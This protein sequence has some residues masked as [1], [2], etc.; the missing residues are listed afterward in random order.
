[1]ETEYSLDPPLGGREKKFQ[2]QKRKN[3]LFLKK[4][5]AQTNIASLVLLTACDLKLMVGGFSMRTIF[6]FNRVTFD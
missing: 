3:R 2:P 6:L 5:T 4:Q 1:V